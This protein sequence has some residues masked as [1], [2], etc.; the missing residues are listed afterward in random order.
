MAF[1]TLLLTEAANCPEFGREKYSMLHAVS[2]ARC[3][4]CSKIFTSMSAGEKHGCRPFDQPVQ[5]MERQARVEPT[6]QGIVQLDTA[7]IAQVTV[8]YFYA[9]ERGVLSHALYLYYCVLQQALCCAQAIQD[10][11]PSPPS[12]APAGV[13]AMSERSRD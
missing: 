6:L 3:H 5:P 8:S 10:G 13:D 1:Q 2:S 4:T 12:A 11:T 7:L 9:S